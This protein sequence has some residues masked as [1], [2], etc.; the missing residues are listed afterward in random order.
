MQRRPSFLVHALVLAALAVVVALAYQPFLDTDFWSPDDFGQLSN[1]AAARAKGELPFAFKPL[2]SG[3]YPANPML[4][5]E[6][7]FFG[8]NARPYA[9]VNLFAHLIN[10]FLAYLLVNALLHDRRSAFLASLLFALS[11]G[12]YGKNLTFAM[13]ISSLLYAMAVLLGTL[14][15]VL[16]EKRNA[17][18]PI[19][20]Y[21]AAF[22]LIF[23]ASLF[24][25]GGTFSLLA[26]FVFYNFFFARE[27]HRPVFH[28]NVLVCLGIAVLAIV[29]RVALRRDAPGTDVE[30]GV[31][32]RNLPGYLILMVF[33]LHK[34]QILESA[35]AVVRLVYEAAPYIRIL[36]G[37]AIVSYSLL[38][39]VFGNRTIRF[40]IAWMYVM[41]VPFAVFRYPADW[42]NLRFLYLVS[43]GFC[44]LLTTGAMYG[45]KLLIQHRIR[46]FVPFGIPLAYVLLSLALVYQLDKKN[47]QLANEPATAE[48]RAQLAALLRP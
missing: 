19:G 1:L 32:L 8:L 27:R 33:P 36:V 28:T 43:V 13:G 16:N 44:V 29:L 37:L 18:R 39:L 2:L 9:I 22:F 10:A 24:M 30:P 41:V 15:Y 23:A 17:G 4:G 25:R 34:S 45:Y 5:L 46:R 26:S 21:A 31:F 47:E 14:L 35:P 11:V 20:L 38:G 7:R 12:S 48:R 6:F 42:L 40:Y 3:G